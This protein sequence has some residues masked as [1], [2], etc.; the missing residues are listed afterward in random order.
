[1]YTYWGKDNIKITNI[2]KLTGDINI[3]SLENYYN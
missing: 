1:M 3:K 2:E